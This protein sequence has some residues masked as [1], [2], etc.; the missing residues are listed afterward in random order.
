MRT[1]VHDYFTPL[2]WVR[3]PCSLF[4]PL[5]ICVCLVVNWVNPA[6]AADPNPTILELQQGLNQLG[7]DVGAE[8][9][10][11]GPKTVSAIKAFQSDFEHEV[12][13]KYSGLLLFEVEREVEN[14][15]LRASP[16]GQRREK[17]RQRLSA[18][19]QS[20][21]ITEIESADKKQTQS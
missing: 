16:E 17:E 15:R 10:L 19:S 6:I 11:L 3:K 7:Y 2:R 1:I 20:D 18:L 12:T 5:L 14:A 9:G 8:D 21:L 4:L 13:G